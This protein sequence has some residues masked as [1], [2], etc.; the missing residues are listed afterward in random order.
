MGAEDDDRTVVMGTR[1]TDGLKAEAADRT[2]AR[3]AT[4]EMAMRM[5][6]ADDND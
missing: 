2:A 4:L 5:V 1:R 6:V 3:A